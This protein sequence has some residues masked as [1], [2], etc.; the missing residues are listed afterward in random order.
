MQ[1]GLLMMCIV[2]FFLVVH[3]FAHQRGCRIKVKSNE[4][5]VMHMHL[6]RQLIQYFIDQKNNLL[7]CAEEVFSMMFIHL[8][9]FFHPISY[10]NISNSPK[11]VHNKAITNLN[12]AFV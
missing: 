12:F 10:N 6:I 7:S 2:A 4:S 8:K 5:G 9:H 3:L 1:K 11:K